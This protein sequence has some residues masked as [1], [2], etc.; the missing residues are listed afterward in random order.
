VVFN[1]K[2]KPLLFSGLVLFLSL[3]VLLIAFFF[4]QT[5]IVYVDNIKLFEGFNM[6]K[7]MKKKGEIQFQYQKN[8]L[9]SIYKT[10]ATL[11]VNKQELLSK[12][13]VLE[14]NE[15]EKNT[16]QYAI[17]E[18]EKI[19]KR[20]NEYIKVYSLNN[21][22]KIVLGS[23]NQQQVLYADSDVDITNDLITFVNKRYEGD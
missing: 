15:L 14:R 18:S 2:N 7:E 17:Q 5:D 9:D 1:L 4:K 13:F 20:L 8:R 21:G 16:Q 3:L 11:P 6:T 23:T 10:I 19:W 12:Q 22:Y